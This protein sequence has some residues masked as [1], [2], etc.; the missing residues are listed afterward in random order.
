MTP[1]A[2]VPQVF[3]VV[4]AGM[5]LAGA[6]GVVVARSVFTSALWLVLSLFGVAGMYML[7]NAGFLAVVQVLVYVGAVSVLILFA[8]MLT[9]HVMGEEGLTNTQW[10]L[11]GIVALGVFGALAVLAYSTDWPLISAEV[12]RPGGDAGIVTAKISAEDAARVGLEEERTASGA[13]V[14]RF[15]GTIERLGRA[16]MTEYLLQF[17]VVSV[18]LLAA[19]IGAIAIARE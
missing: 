8:V 16:F 18:L 13:V 3:F 1:E 19:L 14:Q 10:A 7:L 2:L 5:V 15:P 12:W 11:A 6:V 9:P 4:L 17:E